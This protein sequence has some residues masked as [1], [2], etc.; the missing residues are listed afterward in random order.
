MNQVRSAFVIAAI[1]IPCAQLACMQIPGLGSK[2]EASASASV[3][4]APPAETTAAAAQAAAPLSYPAMIAAKGTTNV[5][6][7]TAA[8]Q[9]ADKTSAQLGFIPA[10]TLVT[11]K[12]KLNEWSLVEWPTGQNQVA[13]GWI[14]LPRSAAVTTSAAASAS[15][16]ASASASAAPTTSAKASASASVAP[17]T[18]ATASAS[19][20]PGLGK[21]IIKDPKKK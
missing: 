1:A 16:S 10:G 14:E 9:A 5:P 17:P 21:I 3:S 15:V 2:D 18:T 19:A 13:S 11:I 8:F 20:K 4:A 6:T 7:S 12:G